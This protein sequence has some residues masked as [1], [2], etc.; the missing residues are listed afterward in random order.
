VPPSRPRPTRPRRGRSVI[1]DELRRALDALGD[2]LPGGRVVV[3]VRRAFGD[4]GV[5]YLAGDVERVTGHPPSVYEAP[6]REWI[7]VVHPGDR[8]TVLER[9]ADLPD[10]ERRR[11]EYRVRRPDGGVRWVREELS[12]TRKGPGAPPEVVGV[13]TD[14]TGER[15]A[16]GRMSRLEAELWRA[17][18]MEALGKVSAEIAH[19]FNNLLTAILASADL[20]RQGEGL[21]T[22][23]EEDVRVIRESALRG[24]D[25]VRRVLSFS[26]RV[27]GTPSETELSHTVEALEPILERVVGERV[28]LATEIDG[29]IRPVSVDRARIEQ[30]VFN[31]VENAREAIP[32]EGRVRLV[33]RNVE[34]EEAL[35]VE[36][37]ELSPGRWVEVSVRDTGVGI[38][39]ETRERIFEPYFS[40]K[41]ERAGT[42]GFGLA[43]VL[44][45]VQAHG[46]GV[47]LES[48]PGRGTVFRIFL[49]VRSG[50]SG[51]VP[52]LGDEPTPR[53]P[54]VAPGSGLRILVVDDDED[55]R[56]VVER[57]L[58]R[59][60]HSVVSVGTAADALQAFDRLPEDFDLLVADVMLPDRSG[61]DVHRALERRV[62]TLPVI[63]L[64]GHGV[65]RAVRE[66]MDE[67]GAVF[68][69]KP[70]APDELI[71]PVSEVAR[72][73][74][75]RDR[76][77]GD[78]RTGTGE[79]G[80]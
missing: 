18:K 36:G 64:S 49:P 5:T 59:E 46:G 75:A 14:V 8:D 26:S 48:E 47:R 31:L 13:L 32:G 33:V 65:D 25:L 50:E 10:R 72:R 35:P 3:L 63:Y 52:G 37:G 15:T 68:L 57:I 9:L 4:H 24:R 60:G 71:D 28:E 7:E 39:D 67:G 2:H 76:E 51:A 20:L 12:V 34:S 55:V 19:D 6:T 62:G 30:V 27:P 43:T 61:P 40:T 42:G 44:R 21:R 69:H 38:S 17:R 16:Q 11:L 79:P 29:D 77:P 73:L 45:I 78:E 22:E 1:R 74:R 70:F 23:D 58:V 80:G 56:D 53:P 66:G 54:G 41:G